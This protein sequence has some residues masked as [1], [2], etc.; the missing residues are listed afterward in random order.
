MQQLLASVKSA[1]L[2]CRLEENRLVIAPSS[3]ASPAASQNEAGEFAEGIR[4][5]KMSYRHRMTTSSG[6]DREYRSFV[7]DCR[8]TSFG[9][10]RLQSTGG[11]VLPKKLS[12]D[13][14][15][16]ADQGVS[17]A[18]ALKQRC[19]MQFFDEPVEGVLCQL[20]DNIEGH[21]ATFRFEPDRCVVV[22]TDQA[23]WKLRQKT[24]GP[25]YRARLT[26]RKNATATRRRLLSGHQ[27]SGCVT[28]VGIN[29]H[30]ELSRSG[31]R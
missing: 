7:S 29:D 16:F 30:T 23:N 9:D 17:S 15:S 14:E 31:R 24:L 4:A 2:N 5:Y 20:L 13:A 21:N 26:D 25:L 3:Q 11:L 18:T 22:R 27:Y 12:L 1:G 8:Q 28:D 10:E 19:S 6:I